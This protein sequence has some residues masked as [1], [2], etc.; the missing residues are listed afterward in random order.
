[1]AWCG[2]SLDALAGTAWLVQHGDAAA[3]RDPLLHLDAGS[4]TPLH[5]RVILSRI[6]IRPVRPRAIVMELFCHRID[7]STTGCTRVTATP[8]TCALHCRHKACHKHCQSHLSYTALCLA[9]HVSRKARPCIKTLLIQ[10]CGRATMVRNRH[11]PAVHKEESVPWKPC[12]CTALS[13]DT[14]EHRLS[15]TW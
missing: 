1:M 15:S 8:K 7:Q 13:L 11:A 2:L 14:R 10:W 3:T 5:S 6:P 4:S 12:T 9:H